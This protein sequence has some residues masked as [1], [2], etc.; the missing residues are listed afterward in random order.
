L[1]WDIVDSEVKI[2]EDPRFQK[3]CNQLKA[4]GYP[5][6]DALEQAIL[7]SSMTPANPNDPKKFDPRLKE[8]MNRSGFTTYGEM[9]QRSIHK[10]TQ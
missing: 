7:F 8:W 1:P 6:I 5:N 9:K 2:L 4:E 10:D 3:A